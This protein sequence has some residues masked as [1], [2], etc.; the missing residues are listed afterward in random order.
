MFHQARAQR[1]KSSVPEI[2]DELPDL[3]SATLHMENYEDDESHFLAQKEADGISWYRDKWD[4]K[5]WYSASVLRMDDVLMKNA[6]LQS[7]KQAR[8]AMAAQ[9]AEETA[10]LLEIG[11]YNFGLSSGSDSDSSVE[12]DEEMDDK[13]KRSDEDACRPPTRAQLLT[14]A[15]PLHAFTPSQE[16][17]TNLLKFQSSDVCVPNMARFGSL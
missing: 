13:Y 10:K 12:D 8:V 11:M 3:F 16:F 2:A 14:P 9:R 1:A 5:T 6:E 17:R 4:V 7:R 15:R